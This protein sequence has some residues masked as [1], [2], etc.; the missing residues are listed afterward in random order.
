MTGD[1][2]TYTEI[3]ENQE[4]IDYVVE[5]YFPDA[6]ESTGNKVGDRT[7]IYQPIW[8][9]AVKKGRVFLRPTYPPIP[10]GT[11]NIS[12]TSLAGSLHTVGWVKEDIEREL[13]FVNEQACTPP[14]PLR[15]IRAIVASITRYERSFD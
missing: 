10:D 7:S 13:L 15:E 12:L 8:E 3:I 1:V 5:K 4:A 9:D 11:R 14:L 6:R 2:F